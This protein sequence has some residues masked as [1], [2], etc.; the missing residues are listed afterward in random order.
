M[1]SNAPLRRANAAGK[2]SA[3]GDTM[4]ALNLCLTVGGWSCSPVEKTSLVR[5]LLVRSKEG[6]RYRTFLASVLVLTS[7]TTDYLSC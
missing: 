1:G 5:M 6:G 4:G 2:G 7:E 3:V